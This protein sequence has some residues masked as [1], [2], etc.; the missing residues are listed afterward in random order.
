MARKHNGWQISAAVILSIIAVV[1]A[2]LL[3]WCLLEGRRNVPLILMGVAVLAFSVF[4]AF[5]YIA[6]PDRIKAK[7]TSRMLTLA[8]QMLGAMEGEG[9]TANSAQRICELLLP[10]TRGVAVAITDRTTILG[11]VGVSEDGNPSGLPIRTL[12]T[13]DTLEDG[14]TRVMLS[15]QEIGFKD[16]VKA[17]QA[18]IISPLVMSNKV[19]GT[20]KFY[21]AHPHF[22][23]DTEK[24]IAEGFASILSTQIAAAAMEQQRKLATSMELRALQTQ[25]NPHFLFNTLNT[26]AAF[27]R[28]DP[29]K[30]RVLLREFATFYRKTLENE[31]DLIELSKEVEQTQRYFTFELAR[32]GEDMLELD[33]DIP[34]EAEDILIPSFMIQPI[35]ENSVQ[36][37]RPADRK[38]T[39]KVQAHLEDDDLYIVVSDDGVGMSEEVRRNIMH[40]K[41]DTGLGI[42]I[43]NIKERVTGYFGP[44]SSMDFESTLGK[45]TVV[46][47]FLKGAASKERE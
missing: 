37:A 19:V 40:A 39:V 46:T 22:I 45:G 3:M 38:L 10:N 16:E 33:V 32:F 6:G 34:E 13:K 23:N 14:A 15:A 7:N 2:G 36:H 41:S 12:A 4:G 26:I 18:A 29:D 27:I 11:Y 1:A 47:L 5:W 35:V 25:I 43:R 31:G 21:Y 44:D 28:M 9:L 17:I 20:L 24:S 42:A 8:N 30:A